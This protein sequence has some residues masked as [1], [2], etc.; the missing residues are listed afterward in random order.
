MVRPSGPGR[1]AIDDVGRC[2]SVRFL[3]SG[4]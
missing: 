2:P 1:Q 4:V 3:I